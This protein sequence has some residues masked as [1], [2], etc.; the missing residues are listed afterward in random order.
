MPYGGNG[1]VLRIEAATEAHH[2]SPAACA[3]GRSDLLKK[4]AYAD[5]HVL[6]RFTS[7]PACGRFTRSSCLP[8]A[9]GAANLA[10]LHATWVAG[11]KPDWPIIPQD[12]L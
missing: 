1:G 6:N 3:G 2:L 8:T 10:H 11:P 9:M 5:G 12:A 7:T 4:I